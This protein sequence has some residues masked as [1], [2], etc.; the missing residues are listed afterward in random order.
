MGFLGRFDID[1]RK[2]LE[3]VILTALL[4]FQDSSDVY[5]G[6]RD[7]G[8][9]PVPSLSVIRNPDNAPTPPPKPPKK[10]G[11]DRVVELQ[12]LR[13]EVNEVEVEEECGVQDYAQ[14]CANLLQDDA[15]LF[16]TV[17]SSA[18]KDVPKV[19][20]VVEETKRIRHKAGMS[21]I[22]PFTPLCHPTFIV[23]TGLGQDLH[24]YVLYDTNPKPSQNGPRRINLDEDSAR[25]KDPKVQYA[26]PSNL[27]IHLSKIPMPELEPRSNTSSA[28]RTQSTFGGRPGPSPGSSRK[29]SREAEEKRREKEAKKK[30]KI[31]KSSSSSPPR[32]HPHIPSSQIHPYQPSP[33]PSQLNNPGIYASP[34]VPW[35]GPPPGG[36]PPSPGPKPS[37]VGGL[38]DRFSSWKP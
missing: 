2:G 11:L 28:H 34:P 3:I 20:Q 9:S 27:T 18:S 1:D 4:S 24:Q 14:Y 29:A 36:P 5:H 35:V 19:L 33:S 26:P 8:S 10:T 30:S 7:E 31:K 37:V 38:L 12:A 23:T 6:S 17:I 21:H 16:I 13:K 25:P 32:L 22:I 15:M